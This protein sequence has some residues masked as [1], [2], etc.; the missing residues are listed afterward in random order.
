MNQLSMNI[1]SKQQ[2]IKHLKQEIE[3]ISDKLGNELQVKEFENWIL[4]QKLEKIKECVNDKSRVKNLV[5][6]DD[7]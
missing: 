6:K 7:R 3:R 5:K 1:D 2:E 4:K